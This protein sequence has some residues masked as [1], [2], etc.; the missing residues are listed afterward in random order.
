MRVVVVTFR[1]HAGDGARLIEALD[2]ILPDTAGF[3]GSLGVELLRDGDDGDQVTM[4]ER[5]ETPDAYVAYRAWRASQ[6]P[7]ETGSLLASP[8]LMSNLEPVA[9]YGDPNAPLGQEE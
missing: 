1:A 8:P 4:I 9:L 2:A 5:W 7:T 3:P 6:P